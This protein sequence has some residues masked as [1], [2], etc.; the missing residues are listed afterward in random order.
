MRFHVSSLF[1]LITPLVIAF[2]GHAHL[3][4]HEHARRADVLTSLV[5]SLQGDDDHGL[6]RLVD[7]LKTNLED[8]VIPGSSTGPIDVSGEHAFQAPGPT[9]QRGPCPALNAL[10]N[11]GYISRNGITSLLTV[12]PAIVRVYGMGL[13]VGLILTVM[14]VV[15]SGN[16][17]SLEPSF[18][19]GGS[20][21]RVQNA[22]GNVLG[23]LNSPQGIDHSHNIIEA[24]SS[25][26]RD[27][28]YVHNNAWTMNI[29]HFQEWHDMAD[30]NG[31][32]SFDSTVKFASKRFN[33][34]VATNPYFYYGPFTGAIARNAGYLFASRILANHTDNG[35]TAVLNQET[36]KSFWAVTTNPDGSLTYT[37]GHERIPPNWYRRSVSYGV[38]QINLDVVGMGLRYPE[39]IS[40]GGNTGTVNS[41]A[42][43][44]PADIVGSAL[45]TANLLEGNNLL[46]FALEAVRVASPNYLANLFS[47][48]SLPLNLIYNILKTPLLNLAC[49]TLDDLTYGG[50]PLLT[51]LQEKYPGA[52][53]SGKAL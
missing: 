5:G 28:L 34:S 16:L 19:I 29:T 40:I 18:S 33:D 31:V 12:L 4:S 2:P 43:I 15:W 17:L 35:D 3:S 20:D 52:K 24:D 14:G 48:I 38:T 30:A 22:L 13:D 50:Q 23:L 25:P 49:P 53:W 1:V 6:I 27:D 39:L 32:I 45:N 41:F 21:P 46:C 44:N 9:D 11:H 10:A 42:G 51:A 47:T 37:E 36:L 26:T 7:E 8:V